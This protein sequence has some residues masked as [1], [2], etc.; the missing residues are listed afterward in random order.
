V[1][2]KDW[3]IVSLGDSYASGEGAPDVPGSTPTWEDRRCH[4]SAN[5]G[6]A[7]AALAFE[8][9]DP[10][11]SVTFLSFACSGATISRLSFQDDDPNKPLG[12]GLLGG[13]RGAEPP[14]GTGYTPA[15]RLP[16]Q[17]D[18]LALALNGRP[19][20]ALIISGGGNDMGFA[21]VAKACVEAASC[22]TD[23]LV[24]WDFNPASF[25]QGQLSTVVSRQAG[26]LPGRYDALA[27]AI[28]DPAPTGRP[29][30]NVAHVF[31]TEYPDPTR[32]DNGALC[33]AILDDT[34]LP[35]SAMSATE[36][37]AAL[38]NVLIPLNSA[39]QAAAARNA[40]RGWQFV[41]GI[42]ARFAGTGVGHGYCAADHWIRRYSESGS[43]Q[44][45][46]DGSLHPN[47]AGQQVVRDQVRDALRA[48]VH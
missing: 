44:G 19:I 42:S 10:R 1:T 41:S 45:N 6:P 3:V 17:V 22:F 23:K 14:S 2:V 39:V 46:T 40:Y 8:R 11:T 13:F 35:F 12:T 5:A 38:T 16:A 20:D 4:R 48:T 34:P 7:Q 18:A 32:N 9:V 21:N 36:E 24:W 30:L 33:P 15:E 43:V 28:H 37:Q 29:A 31:L 26:F 27:A 25:L 47:V